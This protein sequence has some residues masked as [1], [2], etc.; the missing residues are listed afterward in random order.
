VRVSRKSYRYVG[1]VPRKKK[2]K[3]ESITPHPQK[4]LENLDF[5]YGVPTSFSSSSSL[6]LPTLSAAR[7]NRDST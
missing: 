7:K 2:R 3:M 6:S 1:L 5:I 4:I